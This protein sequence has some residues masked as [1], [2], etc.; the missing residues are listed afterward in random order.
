MGTP[1]PK[2]VNKQANIVILG[3]GYA[4][5]D[6]TSGGAFE[7]AAN[8]LVTHLI[9]TPPFTHFGN[10]YFNVWYIYVASPE[11]GI[12]NGRPKN[13]AFRC[14]YHSNY[15][16]LIVFDDVNLFGMRKAPNP[17]EVTQQAI[18]GIN[19]D[20]TLV[21]VLV[22]D[23]KVGYTT[24]WNGL[25]QKSS[26][27]IISACPEPV[28]Q[29]LV[30]REV[31]GKGFARLGE[32]DVGDKYAPYYD[33][34]NQIKNWYHLYGFYGNLDVE[35]DPN[36]V[37]WSHFLKHPSKFPELGVFS[38]GLGYSIDIYHP[39]NN[40]VMHKNGALRYDAPSREAII[41]RFYQIWGETYL[42]ATF[43]ALFIDGNF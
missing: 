41:K 1:Y 32:E 4:A 5:A 3:D 26:I 6:L 16:E 42:S 22:N 34:L 11:S 40:N 10:Y 36:L 31:G 27:S 30:M 25:N 15:P 9:T 38:G 29:R 39:D 2:D 13:S 33:V 20:N 17:F 21:V 8:R 7:I 24:G 35:S 12:G 19:M 18:P 23:T 14:Y 28:F 43:Q 37:R